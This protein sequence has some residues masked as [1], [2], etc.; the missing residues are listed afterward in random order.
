MPHPAHASKGCLGDTL[1]RESPGLC[2]CSSKCH[3][4]VLKVLMALECIFQI[5]LELITP[6]PL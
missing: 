2:H 5:F 1:A 6:L 3:L 4:Q